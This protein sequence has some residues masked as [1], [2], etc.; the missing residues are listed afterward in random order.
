MLTQATNTGVK[1]VLLANAG[2]N[3]RCKAGVVWWHRTQT[4][5]T[6]VKHVIWFGGTGRR[7]G[8]HQYH[9]QPGPPHCPSCW[10]MFAVSGR[11]TLW[12]DV[13]TAR[14]TTAATAR[15]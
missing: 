3:Y 7:P 10:T 4:T 14:P 9:R 13:A 12:P 2:F 5:N 1:Q 15:T 8:S 6:A 11:R